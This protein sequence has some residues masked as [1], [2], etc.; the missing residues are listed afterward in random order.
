MLQSTILVMAKDR[1]IAA[2]LGALVELSGHAVAF[3]SDD[4][5]VDA[6]LLRS[7]AGLVLFDCALGIAICSE[8]AATARLDG[9]RLL[10][11]SASHTEREARDIASL[12]GAQCF[13]L[14]V[15]PRE[16][17]ESVDRALGI[18]IHS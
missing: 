12:Y 5:T 8:V 13:V 9:A 3:R 16:F 7:R 17:M 15:K 18:T 10:M 14:P 1:F 4:E 2:L 6:A 11:F